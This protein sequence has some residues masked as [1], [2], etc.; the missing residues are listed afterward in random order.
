MSSLA[1]IIPCFNEEKRLNISAFNHFLQSHTDAHIFFVNDGSEDNTQNIIEKVMPSHQVELINL[2]KNLGKAEAVRQGIIS[3][4]TS[5]LFHYVGYLDADLSTSIEEFYEIYLHAREH[6]ADFI[7][8]ARIKKL[9]SEIKRSFFRHI[10]GRTLVTLLDKKFQLGYY[11]T[12]CGAKLFK[13]SLINAIIEEPFVTTWFF[14][15]EI[16]LRIKKQNNNYVGIEYPLKAWHNVEGS[17]I[18]LSAFPSVCKEIFV[19]LSKY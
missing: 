7:F 16:F 15:I 3:A 6:E 18:D 14:D 5:G 9:G 17:K 11:D 13:A 10:I 1:I 12:Q 19:L 4:Q 8:G 2:S